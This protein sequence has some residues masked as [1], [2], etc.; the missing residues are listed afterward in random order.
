[1]YSIVIA[2]T[3]TT[4]TFDIQKIW[5]KAAESP[6]SV[7]YLL[8]VR[9]Q[10]GKSVDSGTNNNNLTSDRSHRSAQLTCNIDLDST[11][12]LIHILAQHSS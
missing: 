9:L 1:M 8:C 11:I 12:I 7:S 5:P 2:G 4:R 6:L 10:G 3:N